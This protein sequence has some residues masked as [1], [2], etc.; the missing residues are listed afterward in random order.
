MAEKTECSSSVNKREKYTWFH[1]TG[2]EQYFNLIDD[3]QECHD[4]AGNPAA[5]DRIEAMR[6]LLARVNEERG[7]PRGQGGRR[8]VRATG[9]R[10]PALAKLR[11][12]E[13]ARRRAHESIGNSRVSTNGCGGS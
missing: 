12:V 9:R 7:D 8:L 6:S 2:K 4:L 11:Q 5:R 10:T 13:R 3:P 1:H